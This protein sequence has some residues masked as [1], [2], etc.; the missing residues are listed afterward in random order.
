VLALDADPLA[1]EA[2]AANAAAN[3]VC[4]AVRRA[5][6]L[7]DP[8]PQADLGVANLQLDLL[9]PLFDR[10]ALPPSLIV[11]GLLEREEFAPPGYVRI[12]AERADGWQALRFER[13]P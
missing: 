1:V 3:D 12:D 8:L 9:V 5:D 4:V 11:S 13:A 6:A 10:P 2:T 7:T